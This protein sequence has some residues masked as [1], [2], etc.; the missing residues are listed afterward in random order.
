MNI[1]VTGGAGF[2]ASHIVNAYIK[3]GH[4]V[5][6]LDDLSTGKREFVDPEATFYHMDVGADAVEEILEKEKINVI[7]HHA[8]QMSVQVSVKNPVADA[9]SNIIG[10]LQLIQ[11]AVKFQINKFIFASTG[12]ALYGEQDFFPANE[13]LP[14]E[15]ESPYGISKMCV[16]HY[17]RYFSK[18]SDLQPL[19]FRYSNIFGP[20]QNPH[21]EAGVIGIFCHRLNQG[22]PPV[23]NGSGEQTRDYLY[24]DDLVR[25][26]LIALS[27]DCSGTY[28]LGTGREISV[29]ELTKSLIRLSGSDIKP[30]F[31]PEK[32]GEQKR[33]VLDA[34][35]F[36][37]K[38][39]WKPE[40]SFEEGLKK[41]MGYFSSEKS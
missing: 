20:R 21:G 12:G 10:T 23:I 3:A 2:I 6:V 18:N 11:K 8:A 40:C 37:K 32:T 5:A 26:N 35:K 39:Q 17:L 27:P 25:A 15:P 41:T 31:G 7:S 28:N 13:E 22:K 16:E 34:D 9:N 1:L 29:N 4:R 38:F 24:I 14:C 30:Q 36:R 19:I 33:S